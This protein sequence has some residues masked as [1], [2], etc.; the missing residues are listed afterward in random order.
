MPK[1]PATNQKG[2]A[3]KQKSSL[4]LVLWIY[5]SNAFAAMFFA[6]LWWPLL[7]LERQGYMSRLDPVQW[8][9]FPENAILFLAKFISRFLPVVCKS[10][11]EQVELKGKQI[12]FVSNHQLFAMDTFFLWPSI[13]NAT[14][15]YPRG[16]VDRFHFYIPL[17]DRIIL[18]LG[19]ILA[20][21]ALCSKA[22]ESGLPLLVFPGG[23]NEGFRS[24]GLS[25][26]VLEWRKRKGCKFLTIL[27]LLTFN[28]HFSCSC[29][30]CC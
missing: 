3:E 26:Y 14:G 11:V 10:D 23:A 22:M 18:F 21:R 28:R 6:P 5:V 13:I 16:L 12:L 8:T 20:N 4:L 1:I 30:D 24:G 15:I 2:S 27:S 17:W 25:P 29:K 9:C 7:F 19:G